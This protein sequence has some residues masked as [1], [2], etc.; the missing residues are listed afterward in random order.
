MGF[1][2]I[3]CGSESKRVENDDRMPGLNRQLGGGCFKMIWDVEKEV[4]IM[5][6]GKL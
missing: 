1:S 6:R 4:Q 5:T 3:P 2:L